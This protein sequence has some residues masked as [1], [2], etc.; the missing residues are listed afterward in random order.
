MLLFITGI[1]LLYAFYLS[2]RKQIT[3]VTPIEALK[4]SGFILFTLITFLINGVLIGFQIYV[5]LWIQTE[6][7]LSPTLARL[8]LLPSSIFFIIGSFFSTKLGKYFSTE[9]LLIFCMIINVLVSSVL[10]VLPQY[11]PYLT[12]HILACFSVFGIVPTVTQGIVGTNICN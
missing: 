7:H 9:R 1:I 12:L 8:A 11:V 5:P 6:M 2:E 3:P 4:S 10:G